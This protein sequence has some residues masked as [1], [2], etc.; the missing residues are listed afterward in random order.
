MRTAQAALRN[1]H[2]W[3]GLAL[4]CLL[5]AAAVFVWSRGPHEAEANARGSE[6]AS[7]GAIPAASSGIEAPSGPAETAS[8][9]QPAAARFHEDYFSRNYSATYSYASPAYA[10]ADW[11]RAGAPS[12]APPPPSIFTVPSVTDLL[13]SAKVGADV[14]ALAVPSAALRDVSSLAPAAKLSGP[15]PSAPAGLL[16]NNTPFHLFVTSDPVTAAS[17]TASDAPSIT[18]SGSTAGTVGTATGAVS[19]VTGAAGSLLRK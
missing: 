14:P 13:G 9:S 8:A 17:S 16:T 6:P 1:R 15:A 7:P 12:A 2:T 19:T 3:A 5:A 10:P 18:S 11:S 4:G